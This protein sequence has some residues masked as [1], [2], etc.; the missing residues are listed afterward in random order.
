MKGILWKR[1]KH[2]VMNENSDGKSIEIPLDEHEQLLLRRYIEAEKQEKDFITRNLAEKFSP[3][4][5]LY[6]YYA[7]HGC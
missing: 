1:L 2:F 3:E 6:A 7:G 4:V 5:L